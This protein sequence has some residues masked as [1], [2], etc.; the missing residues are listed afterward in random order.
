[1]LITS[2]RQRGKRENKRLKAIL[3]TQII[4]W[5]YNKTT[6]LYL[7]VNFKFALRANLN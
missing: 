3:Y 4:F 5:K 2:Y 1:M 7:P 6:N